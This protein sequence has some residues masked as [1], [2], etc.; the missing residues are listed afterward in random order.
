MQKS[1]FFNE[2]S[3]IINERLIDLFFFGRLSLNKELVDGYINLL[4]Q[5]DDDFSKLFCK[6]YSS[7]DWSTPV[8]NWYYP[9]PENIIQDFS[10]FVL[11]TFNISDA[12]RE[13]IEK[14]LKEEDLKF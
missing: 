12:G 2:K 5:S 8:T 14:F 4:S 9:V 1:P 13:N 7:I 6:A 10:S 11:K 3:E